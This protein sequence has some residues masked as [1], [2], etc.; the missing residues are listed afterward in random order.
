[1]TNTILFNFR[2]VLPLF[3]FL[4]TNY[5]LLISQDF[6]SDCKDAY[7]LCKLGDYYFS[8][9]EG[10][11]SKEDLLIK[12]SQI[13]ETNSIWLQF[14]VEQ[15][16]DLEFVI[17][18]E[19]QEDDI[20]FI[21]YQGD[22]CPNKTPL[23]VMTS[24]QIFGDSRFE[25]CVG[26]TGLRFASTDIHEE[27]GCF[28]ADDNFL[29]PASLKSGNTYFLLVNNFDSANGFSILLSSI[30][31]LKLQNDC[32]NDLSIVNINAYPIPA[33]DLVTISSETQ[34]NTPVEIII[35]DAAGKIAFK[36]TFESMTAPKQIDV[37]NFPSGEY[38][39]QVVSD[40]YKGLKSVV[41]I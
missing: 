32:K 27:D 8:D 14:T 13:R 30:N 38:Y 33:I 26:Q 28:D 25:N 29:K 17:V 31:G 10:F 19:N 3:L 21:L 37:S 7:R 9:M 16:G 41:K 5:G 4:I 6:P 18:P 35:F 2:R 36:N 40:G 39:I 24:G 23:R 34:F 12:K 20:D 11:G 22:K 1:M 15:S